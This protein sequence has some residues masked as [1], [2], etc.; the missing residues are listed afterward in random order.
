MAT[1]K[2]NVDA[3]IKKV[4]KEVSKSRSKYSDKKTNEQIKSF[5]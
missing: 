5:E 4:T 3:L 2:I 1:R